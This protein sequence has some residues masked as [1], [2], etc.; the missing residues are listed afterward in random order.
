MAGRKGLSREVERGVEEFEAWRRTRPSRRARIP[1]ALWARAVQLV[2]RN[3]ISRTART[4]RLN[5][6]E[7]RRR[8][9]GSGRA[10]VEPASGPSFVELPMALGTSARY[11]VEVAKVGGA[12]LRIEVHGEG[13][14]DV[15]SLARCFLQG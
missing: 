6:Q 3:G 5:E 11:V 8:A 1:D 14:L 4:L 15:E 12:R 2:A 10:A 9:A 7:L 13:R